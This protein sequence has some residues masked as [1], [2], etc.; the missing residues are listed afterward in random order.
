[1]E[2]Q[3]RSVEHRTFQDFLDGDFNNLSLH[4]DGRLSLAPQAEVV[5]SL[6]DPIV[7]QAIM[8]M[9]GTLY[10]ATGP[11]GNLWRMSHDGE[12]ELVYT[13][14]QPLIR[15]L[16]LDADGMLYFGTSP[17]GKV[18]RL[19]GDGTVE[20]YYEPGDEYIWD[21]LFDDEGV[22]YVA[23][24]GKGRIHRVHPPVESDEDKTENA[25]AQ[26]RGEIFYESEEQHL[27]TLA[28][29]H[30]ERLLAGSSPNGLVYRF[31]AD[32]RPF[33][34]FHSE[35]AEIK[36]I[37][38]ESSDSLVVA[39]YNRQGAGQGGGQTGSVAQVLQAVERAQ[40]EGS[41]TSSSRNSRNRGRTPLSTLYRYHSD[42]YVENIW[43][44][45]GLAI[46]SLGLRQSGEILVGAGENGL[47]FGVYAIDRW[48]LL[49]AMPEGG[50]LVTL[51]HHPHPE[52]GLYAVTSHPAKVVRMPARDNLSGEFTSPVFTADRLARWGRIYIDEA[53][54]EGSVKVSLR[55]GNTSEPNRSWTDWTVPVP[56][57]A[58]TPIQVPAVRHL[59]YRLHL[60]GRDEEEVGPMVRGVRFFYRFFNAAPQIGAIRRVP[61]NLALELMVQPPQNP[62]VDLDQLFRGNGTPSTGGVRTQLRAFE[63]PGVVTIAWQARDPDDDPLR[64]TLRLRQRGA[65]HWTLLVED[66]AEPFY[67]FEAL[68]YPEG[69]YEVEVT[70]SDHLAHPSGEARS[71]TRRSEFFLIDHTPPEIVVEEQRIRGRQAVFRWRAVDGVSMISAAEYRLNGR[72]P[73]TLLPEDGFFDHREETFVL[74]LNDLPEGR[75]TLLLRAEDEAGNARNHTLSF[76]IG[77]GEN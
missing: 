68:G 39:A 26:A 27:L 74:R 12:P 46:H 29:D 44:V 37:I 18:Y 77:T 69:Y 9:D 33:V 16:A 64:F 5:H 32:G 11:A 13:S 19:L 59:Q 70:A 7:W 73:R 48:R 30:R 57:H 63:R 47:L 3:T 71:V 62:Q 6:P 14:E 28:W 38:P 43:A 8:G 56:A 42:G 75:H 36:A 53:L 35:D 50:E 65:E 25:P 67:S 54:G 1:M 40:Q 15:A 2:A 20:A 66:L 76:H 58:G 17:S 34:L 72:L 24:G 49:Q 10:L 4:Q 51:L 55:G 31:S 22:L 52:E 45:P 21:M 23:T 41:E 61:G 60:E